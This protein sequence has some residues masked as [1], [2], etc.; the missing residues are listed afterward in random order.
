MA[1]PSQR[2]KTIPTDKGYTSA[3]TALA[4]TATTI[5]VADDDGHQVVEQILLANTD[6]NAR[7]VDVHKTAATGTAVA[8][9]NLML[10][11][12]PVAAD[13]TTVI[14]GPFY[15]ND[16]EALRATQN[17]GT[18]INATCVYREEQ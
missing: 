4:T 12:I 8:N 11:A 16:G 1:Q 6:A 18:N 14:D 2:F 10:S 13:D 7:T 5:A 17:A 15:L 9:S 3:P